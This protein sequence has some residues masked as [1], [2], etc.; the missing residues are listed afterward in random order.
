[1]HSSVKQQQSNRATSVKNQR[2]I[3]LC[4][5]LELKFKLLVF[6]YSQIERF[7]NGKQIRITVKSSQLQTTTP[8]SL[9]VSTSQ[10]S[11]G[12]NTS[13]GTKTVRGNLYRPMYILNWNNPLKVTNSTGPDIISKSV[14]T[15]KI[16]QYGCHLFYCSQK[17]KQILSTRTQIQ[18]LQYC[19]FCY[20]DVHID[21]NVNE[22]NRRARLM[23]TIN[24]LQVFD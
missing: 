12:R 17:N 23:P 7:R 22:D 3:F 19:K 16:K 18:N 13:Y 10:Q 4:S 20:K 5:L 21:R 1:M 6:F 14:G 15:I 8:D 2:Q 11:R 9:N 24:Y